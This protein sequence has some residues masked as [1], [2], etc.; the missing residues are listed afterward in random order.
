[1]LS[2]RPMMNSSSSLNCS[3]DVVLDF[4][5]LRLDLAV[6][7]GVNGH[8]IVAA[9]Q[10]DECFCLGFAVFDFPAQMIEPGNAGDVTGAIVMQHRE[11]APR[12][13]GTVSS[14]QHVQ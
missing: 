5:K 1:M 8:G 7:V 10:F 11:I 14:N 3:G 13:R 4:L 12:R 6:G 2:V 9:S